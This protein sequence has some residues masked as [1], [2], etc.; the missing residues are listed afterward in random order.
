MPFLWLVLFLLGF[1]A[2]Y[3]LLVFGQA[4]RF[5]HR[6]RGTLLLQPKRVP[7]KGRHVSYA[8]KKQ[9]CPFSQYRYHAAPELAENAQTAGTESS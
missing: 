7:R 3:L 5:S 1:G 4:L 9:G 6:G 2:W 8:P